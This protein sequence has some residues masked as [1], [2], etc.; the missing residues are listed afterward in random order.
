MGPGVRL[1]P[2]I[3]HPSPQ[4]LAVGSLPLSVLAAYN[5]AP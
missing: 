4:Q 5:L 1:K 3:P 2:S